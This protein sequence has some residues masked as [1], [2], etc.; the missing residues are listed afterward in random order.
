MGGGF[1]HFPSTRVGRNSSVELARIVAMLMIVAHHLVDHNGFDVNSSSFSFE[2]FLFVCMHSLGKIGVVVFFGIS[3][4]YLCAE[5]R[6]TIHQS[7]RR[8]WLLEREVLFYSFVLLGC[9]ILFDRDDLQLETVLKT[10]VPTASGLWWYVTAYVVFLIFYPFVTVGLRLI[11]RRM[12]AALLLALLGMWGIC[13]GLFPG[14][15]WFDFAGDG[16]VGFLYLYILISFYRWY[17]SEIS[18]RNGWALLL[19][20]A[21]VI[22]AGILALQFL[23][24]SLGVTG[25]RQRSDY[26]AGSFR[27]PTLCVGFGIITIAEHYHFEN[28]LVNKIAAATFGVYLISD[29]PAAEHLLWT[30]LFNLDQVY[31]RSYA[32]IWSIGVIALVFLVCTAI[33]LSREY[34]FS[35]T[36]NKHRG[37]LFEH[38]WRRI[39]SSR[40]MHRLVDFLMG[41][42]KQ[43][44]ENSPRSSS[45]GLPL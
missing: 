3:A 9:F 31:S 24:T 16:F 2:Q 32:L 30:K 39:A 1:E 45:P 4:W 29:H 23:G 5:E 6:P 17:L 7:F 22:I 36:V 44:V 42:D 12:H 11:G 15:P 8:V 18:V 38:L 20:G 19:I 13:Y 35:L 37:A 10:F 27:L 26:L 14:H 34:V 43:A 40:L 25:I 28:S 21:V 33:D 41:D